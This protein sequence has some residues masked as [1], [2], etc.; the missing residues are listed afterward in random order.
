M[1]SGVCIP[2]SAVDIDE[3]SFQW[4]SKLPALSLHT[5]HT[6]SPVCARYSR[7]FSVLNHSLPMSKIA[8]YFQ[9]RGEKAKLTNL[10]T[11]LLEF[12]IN[13]LRNDIPTLLSLCLTNRSLAPLCRCHLF[14]SILGGND[15]RFGPISTPSCQYKVISNR[16]HH[17]L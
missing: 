5:L 8:G 3:T 13:F 12:I 6:E 14:T 15:G 10:P 7:H 4:N 17:I 16:T 9:L 11:E 1:S 2:T